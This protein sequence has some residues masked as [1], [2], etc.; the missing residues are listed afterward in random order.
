MERSDF[1]WVVALFSKHTGEARMCLLARAVGSQTLGI[2]RITHRPHGM[3]FC[4][5]R[6]IS[7]GSILPVSGCGNKF[8]HQCAVQ[9]QSL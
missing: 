2:V 8:L 5:C 7:K 3:V 6:A 9:R 4:T 1:W